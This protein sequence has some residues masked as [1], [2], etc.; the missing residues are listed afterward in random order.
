MRATAK[1]DVLPSLP[2]R[3]D[4]YDKASALEWK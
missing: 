2:F 1:A 3:V 4:F